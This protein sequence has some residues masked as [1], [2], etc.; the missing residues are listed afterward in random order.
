MKKI[1]TI[2][3]FSI[4]FVFCAISQEVKVL[5]KHTF[6]PLSGV[7]I[8]DGTKV[9]ITDA[10]GRIDL[11]IFRDYDTLTVSF[12]GYQTLRLKAAEVKQQKRLFLEYAMVPL[13][14]VVVSAGKFETSSEVIPQLKRVIPV[15]QIQQILP[16]SSAE[17]LEATGSAFVQQSQY[18]GGSPVL[19]GFEANKV[20]L[21][22]DGIRM[23]NAIYR[24]GHLQNSITIDPEMLE[25]VEVIYGPGSVM[26]GSDALGGVM[27]FVT[28]KPIFSTS[29]KPVVHGKALTKYGTSTSEKFVSAGVHL[30]TKRIAS[31]THFTFKDLGDLR[32][33][34]IRNPAYGDF[35]KCMY[36]F[37]RI[38]DRDSMVL[39]DNPNIQRNSGYWQMDGIQKLA[40]KLSENHH[41]VVN[42]QYSTSGD[43]P[44]YDRLSEMAGNTLRYAEWHYGPQ[45]RMLTALSYEGKNMIFADNMRIIAAWQKIDEDRIVRRFNNPNRRY[46]LEDVNVFSIN[47]DFSKQFNKHMF[48]YGFE[49]RQDDVKSEA[50]HENINTGEVL[51]NAVSRYPDE[52]NVMHQIAA[53]VSNTWK[54]NEQVALMQGLRYQFITLQSAWTDTM[55]RINGFP[56]ERKLE[57]KNGAFSGM[58]GGVWKIDRHWAIAINLASGFR[59]PNVDDVGK[60]NDSKPGDRL[61]IIPSPDLKPEYAYTAEFTLK[62]RQENVW[63]IENTVFYTYID[64]AIVLRPAKL[65]GQDSVMF[66]GR[67]CEVQANTNAGSAYIAGNQ[68]SLIARLNER[69]SVKTYFTY[70]YGRVDKNTPLDHIPPAFGLTEFSYRYRFF[71]G[72]FYIRY[73]AWKM[74]KD[75]SP[76]GEDNLQYATPWGMPG[77]TTLNAKAIFDIGKHLTFIVAVENIL[78]V[79]YRK[80]AS[81][82]S[83][84][85]RNLI[86]ALR[87]KF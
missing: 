68:F 59:A 48:S 61:L 5:D 75:Y 24:G 63:S 11:S 39:N 41:I 46:Q 74:L 6:L 76:S 57:Q 49:L 70:T 21:V 62:N 26:Y 17:L 82:I 54:V 83:S 67:M 13:N 35:G 23:N 64:N 47:A 16:Q 65:N 55:M 38:N 84:P 18:G 12:L 80:F 56:F 73:S 20:L 53:Y 81:G 42:F 7:H 1:L 14:E 33:G 40:F 32:A 51:Y 37:Q 72:L 71:T 27:S 86:V 8:T 9:A 2:I 45:N 3:I 28:P 87:A 22:I 36:Y 60:V 34:N 78:D 29:D 4:L 31:F 44:R 50:Y 79:H 66:G 77:W 69:V 30:G 52:Y 15:S 43:V 10:S 58:I 85:G 25:K 19:R